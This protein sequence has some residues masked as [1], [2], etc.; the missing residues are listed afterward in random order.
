M[1]TISRDL[2]EIKINKSEQL[3]QSVLN[4]TKYSNQIT[5]QELVKKGVPFQ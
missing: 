2:G 5:A 4:S 1:A 3:G